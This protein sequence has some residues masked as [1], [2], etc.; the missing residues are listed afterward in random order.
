MSKRDALLAST[1]EEIHKVN[2]PQL[3][4]HL[5][6]LLAVVCGLA[7]A[8]LYY[9][10]PVLA[11]IGHE[12]A[13]SVNQVGVLATLSQLGYAVG[14]LLIIPLGDRYNRRTLIVTML[15]AVTVALI[16]MALAPTLMFLS[17][18][19]FA[20]GVT[21]VVP[22]LV[23]PLAASLARPQERGRVVGTVM[24]GLLIGILL[25]RTVSGVLAAHLG[26]RT[27][28]WVAAGLMVLLALILRFLLPL[29][30]P[31]SDMSYTQ[32]LR[33]LWSLVKSEPVLRETS[34]FG[35]LGFAA[36]SAFWATLSFRLQTPPFHYGSEVAGL[37]GLV[38][39]VGALAASFI[40]RLADKVNPRKTIGIGLLILLASFGIFWLTGQYLWGLII[41]VILLDLGAQANQISNQARVYSLNPAARSRLNTI[42][43]VSYFIGGSLGSFLGTYGWDFAGWFGVCCVGLL[44][45]LL[46]LAVYMLNSRRTQAAS[47]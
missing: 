33:S 45:L 10:Q 21:T 25:A 15:V 23:V 8:N 29:D 6:L 39:V 26:W 31:Q 7:A 22:Q 9:V 37:F 11:D 32:L 34:V 47:R 5:V 18:A 28:Y 24:S 30:R 2:A 19:S 46:A 35:A 43:M 38:G 42:Y 14:L 16:A 12:F 40:G 44:F 4:P 17:I 3:S 27:V 20:V 1:E 41:G 36:F 13:V